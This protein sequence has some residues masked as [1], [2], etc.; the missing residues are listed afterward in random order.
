MTRGG[1]AAPESAIDELTSMSFV[2]S[3]FIEVGQFRNRPLPKHTA[4]FILN[5]DHPAVQG[6]AG[7]AGAPLRVRKIPIPAVSRGGN[8][9][10]VDGGHVESKGE[11][12][13]DHLSYPDI[14]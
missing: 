2:E 9:R 12:I 1:N 11:T 3:A 6:D 10:P 8:L 5:P 14:N 7:P 4:L 13:T